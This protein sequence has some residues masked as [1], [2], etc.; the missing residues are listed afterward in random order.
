MSV[1]SSLLPASHP[2]T[3]Q[4]TKHFSKRILRSA[5][6]KANVAVQCDSTNDVLGA[7]HAYT[8]AIELLEKVLNLI[9]K[10]NDK[11]RLQEIVRGKKK[12]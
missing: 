1:E 12:N 11:K 7:V 5:L 8:E 9:E 10:E 3:Q 2:F 6:Q 4:E